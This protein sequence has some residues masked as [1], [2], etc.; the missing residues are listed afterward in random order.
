MSKAKRLN[1]P[2]PLV[3]DTYY[4]VLITGVVDVECYVWDGD[5]I[6]YGFYENGNCF[7]TKALADTAA[8]AVLATLRGLH[9]PV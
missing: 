5:N 3:G 1:Y 7:L 9:P 8:K 2:K 4:V 6:D